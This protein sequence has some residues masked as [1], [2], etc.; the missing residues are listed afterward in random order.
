MENGTD[1]KRVYTPFIIYLAV[2]MGHFFGPLNTKNPPQTDLR[3]IF[4]EHRRFE[5]KL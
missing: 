1:F 3:G 5:N 2:K 4:V